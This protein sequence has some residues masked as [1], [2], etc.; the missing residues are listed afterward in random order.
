MTAENMEPVEIS[1]KLRPGQRLRLAE[2]GRHTKSW[3][4]T[5]DLGAKK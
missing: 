3:Q 4:L 2:H 5:A 1:T